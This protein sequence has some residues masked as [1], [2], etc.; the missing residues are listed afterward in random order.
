MS[1][2]TKCFFSE[3]NGHQCHERHKKLETQECYVTRATGDIDLHVLA[4]DSSSSTELMSNNMVRQQK[5]NSNA[6]RV[7][8]TR[9]IYN[10]TETM[11][12]QAATREAICATALVSVWGSGNHYYVE[13]TK[14]IWRCS[15][16]DT[17]SQRTVLRIR[18]IYHDKQ[19]II[20]VT[21]TKSAEQPTKNTN[22][23]KHTQITS[24][25]NFNTW[26]TYSTHLKWR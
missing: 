14:E 19:H 3:L 9:I 12:R 24:T 21:H 26:T 11:D 20:S 6:D 23:C 17:M 22:K 5:C 4:P 25:S 2:C 8:Y 18:P 15:T 16:T 1:R 7:R 10:G 13:D